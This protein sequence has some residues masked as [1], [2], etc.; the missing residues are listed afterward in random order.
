[1]NHTNLQP[2]SENA[3][4]DLNIQSL[5]K[6]EISLSGVTIA[7]AIEGLNISWINPRITDHDYPFKDSYVVTWEVEAIRPKNK[8]KFLDII[9]VCSQDGYIPANIFHLLSFVHSV[10]DT[11][12]HQSLLAPGSL[13]IDDFEYPGC[14]VLSIEEEDKKLGLGNWRGSKIGGYDILRA[15]KLT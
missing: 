2:H 14:V 9:S 12:S 4:N 5:G 13:C 15:K 6:I 3:H 10:K 7:N 1:M 11:F 8:L